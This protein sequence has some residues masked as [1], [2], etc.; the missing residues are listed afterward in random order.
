MKVQC[1][2]KV[3][4]FLEVTGRRGDGYHRLATLF[5]KINLYDVLDMTADMSG[6][7]ELSVETDAEALSA[8]PDNLV[9]RAAKAFFKSFRI[10]QGVKIILTKRIPMG[11]GLGGGSSDAAGTLLGLAKLF[12]IK[13]DAKKKAT[14]RRIGLSL[15]ADVPFFLHPAPFCLGKGVGERL[16]PV[17]IEKS[18]PY[19]VL[20]F[21]NLNISTPSAFTALEEP[22]RPDVLTRLSHLDKLI[23]CL[24]RGRSVEEWGDLLFNRLEETRLPVMGQV[25]QVRRILLRSGA[26]GARMSGSGSSVFGFVESH[27][28]G[29]RLVK[30]LQGY[31]W[32][33]F[34]TCCNG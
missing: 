19:M 17:E 26:R 25:E 7:I 1:P 27:A 21:P 5:A 33:I 11:A 6:R 23:S 16:S 28:E 9:Y 2:A 10:G 31:P 22:S 29:E 13:L 30:R 34:L 8:G 3:N 32:K 18:L 20:V 4:L 15:G 12:D 14:L 24:Q